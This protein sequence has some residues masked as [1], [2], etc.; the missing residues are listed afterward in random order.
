MSRA[1]AAGLGAGEGFGS[2]VAACARLAARRSKSDRD[3]A[4]DDADL[5]V[6]AD[7]LERALTSLGC[8]MMTMMT[9]M[10]MTTMTMTTTTMRSMMMVRMRMRDDDETLTFPG[11]QLGAGRVWSGVVCRAGDDVGPMPMSH[12]W[13]HA[14]CHAWCHEWGRVDDDDNGCRRVVSCGVVWACR[15]MRSSH[16]S[17]AQRD[18]NGTHAAFV[19]PLS[20][21]LKVP[22]S[23][24]LSDLS[25]LRLRGE[26]AVRAR[27]RAWRAR[28]LPAPE[29]T[30]HYSTVQY[31]T[32]RHVTPRR[33]CPL[34]PAHARVLV[35]RARCQSSAA[36]GDGIG[37]GIG[38]GEHVAVGPRAGASSSMTTMT[39]MTVA[40][41]SLFRLAALLGSYPTE[42]LEESATAT[43]GG[44]GGCLCCRK[45]ATVARTP[46][47]RKAP[48]AHDPNERATGRGA[49]ARVADAWPS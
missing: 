18:G 39:T 12:E 8:V 31:I 47:A 5:F 32:L 4:D 33:Y 30:S 27:A 13:R 49:C 15:H 46:S 7:T 28:L 16:V 40:S 36:G 29:C 3:D 34:P 44:G 14:W 2:G 22:R 9:M 20:H 35:D 26:R 24:Y 43:R 6:P 37:D 19:Q 41:C 48:T 23:R 10:T 45:K 21:L 17:C 11:P 25:G 38:D 1:I 42:P